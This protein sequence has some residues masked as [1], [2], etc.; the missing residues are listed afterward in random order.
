M[1]IVYLTNR[2]YS[3]RGEGNRHAI[4]C[5]FLELRKPNGDS[6]LRRRGERARVSHVHTIAGSEENTCP[7]RSAVR[8]RS[9]PS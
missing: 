1:S 2:H 8:E 5:E 4:P 3:H 7:T 9:L 6:D